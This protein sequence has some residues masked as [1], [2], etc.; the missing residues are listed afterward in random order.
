MA[1]TAPRLVTIADG[2]NLLDALAEACGKADGWLAA[3]GHVDSVE[4]RLAGEGADVRKQLR[5]RLTLAQLSGPFGGPYFATLSRHT[6]TGSELVAGQ[7][8]AARSAGVTSTIWVAQGSV[9]ELV[10]AAPP[11]QEAAPAAEPAAAAK[12]PAAS[13]WAAVASAVAADL[14]EEEVEPAHP[15][16][17]DLVRHFAFGLCEVLQATGDRLKL[18]DVHGQGRIREIATD[19]LDM[20]LQG[21]QNGKRVFKLNRKP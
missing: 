4:L 21:E 12:A 10:D 13:G 17:G 14:K 15:E 19:M 2:E 16:R 1:S 5:G 9:R 18:R 11:R 8:L 20:S 3:V 6:S 7:L